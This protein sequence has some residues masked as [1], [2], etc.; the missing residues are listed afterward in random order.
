MLKK[1]VL[2][3]FFIVFWIADVLMI[4]FNKNDLLPVTRLLSLLSIVLYGYVAIKKITISFILLCVLIVSTGFLF[5]LNAYTISGLVSLCCLRAIW[6]FLLL[7]QR[8]N[9]KDY[10]SIFV[11]FGVLTCAISI[12]LYEISA[13]SV[14]FYLSIFTTVSLMFLLAVS[15]AN[16]LATGPKYGNVEMLLSVFIFVV[17]DSLSGAK[18]I[19]GTT[20]FYLM[21]S[22]LLYNSAYYFLMKSLIKH[23]KH[24]KH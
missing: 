15:F 11:I 20:T 14:F 9:R 24:L 19:E 22:V 1:Q 6:S 23:D 16:I 7:Y 2:L 18:K 10:K 4:Y 17:S 13:H 3:S 12:V 8:P 5:S 21:L